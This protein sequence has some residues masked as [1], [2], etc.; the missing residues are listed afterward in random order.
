MHIVRRIGRIA[1]MTVA[2]VMALALSI[3]IG[4]LAVSPNEELRFTGLGLG[5]LALAIGVGY[6]VGGVRP[7]GTRGRWLGMAR[8]A[9]LS[10]QLDE[11]SAAAIAERA[12]IG[13]R[14]AAGARASRTPK[15]VQ[16]LAMAGAAPAEIA[17]RTGLAVDAVAM[18]LALSNG[19]GPPARTALQ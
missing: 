5:A 4:A 9:R 18:L 13:T 19:S 7:R 15:A 1:A 10:P 12:G 14:T 16:S 2:A 8:R 6:A 11:Q 17:R 3:V